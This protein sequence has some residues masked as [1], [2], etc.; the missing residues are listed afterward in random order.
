MNQSDQIS[1][2]AKT[3]NSPIRA[4]MVYTKMIDK[5]DTFFD[6]EKKEHENRMNMLIE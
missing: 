5:Y 2:Y 4:R 6:K 1:L 3:F